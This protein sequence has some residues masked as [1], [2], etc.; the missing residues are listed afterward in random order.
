MKKIQ[1]Q[2]L[3]SQLFN[4]TT[5]YAYGGQTKNGYSFSFPGPA[6]FA[7]KNVPV[8]IT[9]RN[10]IDGPHILPVDFTPPFMSTP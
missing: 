9:W 7:T 2:I 10:L 3:P 4:K 6:V 8:R 1:Q 5:I